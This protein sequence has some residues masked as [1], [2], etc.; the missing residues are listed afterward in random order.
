MI[1]TLEK[2]RQAGAVLVEPL[3]TVEP[4]DGLDVELEGAYL[5]RDRSIGRFEWR[6]RDRGA[7]VGEGVAGSPER[8][9]SDVRSLAR[10]RGGGPP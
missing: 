2:L 4:I 7:V 3:E 6:A 5:A 1:G 9:R 8:A 10:Q